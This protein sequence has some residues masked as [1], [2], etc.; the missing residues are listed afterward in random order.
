MG[1]S[2]KTSTIIEKGGTCSKQEDYYAND[3]SQRN[4]GLDGFT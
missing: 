3:A 1:D 2:I 4:L